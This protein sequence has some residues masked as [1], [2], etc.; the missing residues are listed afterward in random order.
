MQAATGFILP[1]LAKHSLVSI[2]KLCDETCKFTF[3]KQ[4]MVVTKQDIHVWEGNRDP[5]KRLWLLP[6]NKQ[7]TH[8]INTVYKIGN[9]KQQIEYLHACSGYPPK[10]AWLA[11][12][13]KG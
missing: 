9:I 6:L 10:Q 5:T 2:E 11:A 3:T 7:Q 13:D 12:V 1:G 4:S 8:N